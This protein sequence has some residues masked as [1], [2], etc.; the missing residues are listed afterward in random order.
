M[1]ICKQ[2]AGIWDKAGFWILGRSKPTQT[3][4]SKNQIPRFF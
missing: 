3:P 1:G 4:N 2:K